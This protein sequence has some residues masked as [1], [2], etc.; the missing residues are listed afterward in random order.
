MFLTDT[1]SPS[2]WRLQF[3]LHIL[4][5]CCSDQHSFP[6]IPFSNVW[7]GFTSWWQ[8]RWRQWHANRRHTSYG[9]CGGFGNGKGSCGPVDAYRCDD[10]YKYLLQENTMRIL[11]NIMKR[12]QNASSR[13]IPKQ[14]KYKS[15]SIPHWCHKITCP[16]IRLS[17][18]I[19]RHD[20][21]YILF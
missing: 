18:P 16:T 3:R 15:V 5:L 1:H 9:G 2:C 7:R 11:S 19:F 12:V 6:S 17:Y 14:T 20:F 21:L 8:R 10:L 13:C 4:R